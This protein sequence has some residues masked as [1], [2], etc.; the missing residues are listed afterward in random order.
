[1]APRSMQLLPNFVEVAKSSQKQSR[2]A[3]QIRLAIEADIGQGTVSQFFCGKPIERANFHKIC[4]LLNLNPIEVGET[5]P[6]CSIGKKQTTPLTFDSCRDQENSWC[7]KLLEPHALIKLQAPAQF[8]KTSLMWKML[9]RAEQQGHLTLY[10]NLNSI[11]LASFQDIQS[12]FRSFVCEIASEID[13]QYADYL[14]PL[15]QYDELAKELGHNRAYLKYL[16][17]LQQKI[18]LPLTVGINKIDR[19]LDFPD[20]AS[21]F[22]RQLRNMHEKSKKRGVWQDFRMVLAYSIPNIQEF[23]KV[24]IHCSPFN[25]GEIIELKEFS[26]SEVAELATKKG[27]SINREKIAELM[28]SIGGIPSL[29]KLTL[30]YLRTAEDDSS[31]VEA[32]YQDHLEILELWLQQRGLSELMQQIA[33]NPATTTLSRQQQNPLHCQG[34]I[35]FIDRQAQARCELSRQG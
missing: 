35:I 16:E 15:V 9:E 3:T 14:M 33:I 29:V 12:F 25:V 4:E 5:P 22:F 18:T 7:E 8:G 21:E 28:K 13:E 31:N 10:I 26:V 17:H 6:S 32:V 24:E 19:L 11:D 20:I 27:L 23:V 30:N 1:M 2:Y 34:L